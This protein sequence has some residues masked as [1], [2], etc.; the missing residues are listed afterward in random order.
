MTETPPL[1]LKQ[2]TPVPSAALGS[3]VEA[4]GDAVGSPEP[5][6]EPSDDRDQAELLP[7][8]MTGV[9]ETSETVAV[10]VPVDETRDQEA[11][12]DADRVL[13]WLRYIEAGLALIAIALATTT[14]ILRR[15]EL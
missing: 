10:I 2:A 13:T 1:L 7:P 8:A 4:E 9:D 11:D 12:Q 14:L 3:A 6:P 5:P 15:R